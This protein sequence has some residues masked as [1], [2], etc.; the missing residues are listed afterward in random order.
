MVSMAPSSSDRKPIPL[1]QQFLHQAHQMRHRAPQPI[2]PPDHQRIPRR[3]GFDTR[4]EP[5][6]FGASSGRLVREDLVAS[7]LVQCI[8]LQLQ[9][10]VCSTHPGVADQPSHAAFLPC[11]SIVQHKQVGEIVKGETAR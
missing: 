9:V 5:G 2:Q 1:P 7:R 11:F 10:L 4:I 3:Q 8:Q 6:P